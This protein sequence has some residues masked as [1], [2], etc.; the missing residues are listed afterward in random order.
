M[1]DGFDHVLAFAHTGDNSG[2]QSA[3]DIIAGQRAIEA[4]FP[5]AAVS[6]ASLEPYAHALQ[7]LTGR[8]PV[9]EEEIG[10]SWIHGVGSDPKEGCRLSR[11]AAGARTGCGRD[12]SPPM[13]AITRRS[14]AHCS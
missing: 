6:A 13:P 3:A 10:N 12:G 2:P 11:V 4:R 14:R 9:L 5:G 7:S 8:L 1:I